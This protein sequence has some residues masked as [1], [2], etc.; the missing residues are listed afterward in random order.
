MSRKNFARNS[1]LTDRMTGLMRRR[2]P[3]FSNRF[4][5]GE[6]LFFGDDLFSKQKRDQRLLKNASCLGLPFSPAIGNPLFPVWNGPRPSAS[7]ARFGGKAGDQNNRRK[8]RAGIKKENLSMIASPK[9]RSCK[10]SWALPPG[11]KISKWPELFKMRL[12][13]RRSPSA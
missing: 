9:S 3:L 8:A 12:P 1:P 7:A 11:T 6:K 10:N 4:N 5:F 13:T 2:F